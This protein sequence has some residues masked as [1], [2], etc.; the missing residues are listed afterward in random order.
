MSAG[1]G[2]WNGFGCCSRFEQSRHQAFETTARRMK[3]SWLPV[4]LISLSSASSSLFWLLRSNL[5]FRQFSVL[6][7]NADLQDHLGSLPRPKLQ[8][9]GEGR[10]CVL[11]CEVYTAGLRRGGHLPSVEVERLKED[12][13]GLQ[14]DILK[15]TRSAQLVD[16]E[17]RWATDAYLSFVTSVSRVLER[18]GSAG[19]LSWM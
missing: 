11:V 17:Q 15:W 8:S 6:E 9:K 10:G 14:A 2:V 1:A 3:T 7:V 4:F 16:L 19:C 18:G 5:D 12:T 13:S